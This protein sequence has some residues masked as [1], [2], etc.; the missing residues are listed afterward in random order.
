[1]VPVVMEKEN[2]LC[3]KYEIIVNN[4][5]NGL[6]CDEFCRS[7]FHAKCVGI[8]D[9]NYLKISDLGDKVWWLCGACVRRIENRSHTCVIQKSILI[10]MILLEVYLRLSRTCLTIMC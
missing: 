5:E 4:D 10:Y 1:M 7:W 9:K 8:D 6:L 2:T 3:L